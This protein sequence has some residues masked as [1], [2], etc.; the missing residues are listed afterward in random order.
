M[1]KS[2]NETECLHAQQQ[3][4]ECK[5]GKTVW[6]CTNCVTQIEEYEDTCG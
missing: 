2:R 4:V 3:F 6:Q 1:M 5:S